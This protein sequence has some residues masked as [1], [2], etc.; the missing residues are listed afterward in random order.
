M[1]SSAMKGGLVLLAG[2]LAL[3]PGTYAQPAPVDQ[4]LA[5]QRLH[6]LVDA[7]ADKDYASFVANGTT[8]LKAA[9]TKTQFEASSDL[10]APRLKAGCDIDALGE[11]NQHGFQVYLYRLRC[12]DK[13]DDILATMTLKDSQVAG[14]YF[15]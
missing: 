1:P 12:K 6:Q 8:Q 11:L 10:L 14:I 3:S 5:D 13:G 9:L 4:D 2:W 15:K 7:E